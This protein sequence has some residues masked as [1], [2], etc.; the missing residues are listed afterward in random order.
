MYQNRVNPFGE[1]IK[2]PARGNLMGNRGVIHNNHGEIKQ[3]YKLKAWIT[4]L[5]QFKGR[6]FKI[7][8]P[9][10]WTA[11]F[12][13]DEATAFAAGHRPCNECRRNDFM[14][15]KSFWIKGNPEYGFSTKTKIAEIDAVLHS[16]RI[17]ADKE[18]V[19][20]E[21]D[22]SEIPNGTF[23]LVKSIPHLFFQS[24]LY[25]WTPHGYTN[26]TSL[27]SDSRL[28]I[29]TPKSIVKMFGA[30]YVP[31]HSAPVR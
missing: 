15:F 21:M 1:L 28:T 24:S 8:A 29:L 25:E 2:T 11:L 19:I 5:L 3:P 10:R 9:N 18:K 7:M 22:I 6:K 27:P 17:N 16:E 23:V 14:K 12:F 26:T 13:L 30:G 31:Q 20:F 4:C